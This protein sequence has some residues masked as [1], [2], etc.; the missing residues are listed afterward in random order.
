MQ[1]FSENRE[2]YFQQCAVFRIPTA[3]RGDVFMRAE[4]PNYNADRKAIV[5]VVAA[6]FLA[7]W[8]QPLSS[9]RDIALGDPTSWPSDYKYKWAE[10][11]FASGAEN[12]VPLAEVS[13]G[14][15]TSDLIEKRRHFL[16]FT[17]EVI[18]AQKGLPWLGFTDGITRTI[19]LLANG[20]SVFPVECALDEAADL[21]QLAGV[22]GGKP[23][24]LSDLIRSRGR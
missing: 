6:R 19:W 9:H 4:R 21:Q 12:P 15:S 23:V 18:I 22:P 5:E 3:K 14:R 13:C 24:V 11:G 20:A 16:F 10:D 7:L 8:R 17:K 2:I 1:T